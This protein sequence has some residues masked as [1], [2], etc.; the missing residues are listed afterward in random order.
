MYFNFSRRMRRRQ[1]P[2]LIIIP[3]R[4][5]GTPFAIEN[6]RRRVRCQDSVRIRLKLQWHA[7]DLIHN[8]WH[9][10]QLQFQMSH[11]LFDRTACCGSCYCR[12]WLMLLK[13]VTGHGQG[14]DATTIA[15]RDGFGK[16]FD[17]ARVQRCRIQVHERLHGDNRY[18]SYSMPVYYRS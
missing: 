15:Q 10:N 17:T 18:R 1:A 4:W 13:L 9:F 5:Q 8:I 6:S 11:T 7:A 16:A 3:I 2:V 12:G 14:P